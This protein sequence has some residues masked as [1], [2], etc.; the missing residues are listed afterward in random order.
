MAVISGLIMFISLG[1][2]MTKIAD[3]SEKISVAVAARDLRAPVRLTNT[4]LKIK[5]V[6]KEALPRNVISGIEQ[7]NGF[8]LL[9]PLSE[10]EVLTTNHLTS[11]IS[12]ETDSLLVA[13]EAIGF[14]LPAEWLSARPAKMSAG[15]NI[16]VI[17]SAQARPNEKG[18]SLLGDPV[19]ILKVDND[20][21]GLPTRLLLNT[22]MAQAGTILQ[23]RANGLHL[24]VLLMPS[25]K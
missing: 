10:N 1:V 18:A 13:K 7:V 19:R 12:S 8:T 2:C 11:A 20:K 23:A 21:E 22:N 17:A 6:S 16:W 4:D 24:A 3:K 9:Y 14:S 25:R 15:D 5:N